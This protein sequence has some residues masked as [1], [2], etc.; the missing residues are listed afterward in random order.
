MRTHTH[1]NASIHS[2]SDGS[3]TTCNLLIM[4]LYFSHLKAAI[5]AGAVPASYSPPHT[6]TGPKGLLSF[7]ML[8]INMTFIITQL[9][10]MYTEN[11][12]NIM[13]K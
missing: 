4:K 13:V 7:R 2:E 6:H 8:Y 9:G 12:F 3:V 11:H 10:N 5:C 1:T